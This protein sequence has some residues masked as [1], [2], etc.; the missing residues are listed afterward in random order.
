MNCNCSSAKTAQ[1]IGDTFTLDMQSCHAITRLDFTAGGD[2]RD[3]PGQ[4][5]VTVSSDCTTAANGD[6][7][8]T[9]TGFTPTLQANE[10][11]AM[12]GKVCS[13]T[14]SP[15][16]FI[17]NFPAGTNARCIRMKLT[18]ILAAGGGIWWAIDELHV[19]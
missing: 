12:D 3:V 6:I 2:P 15:C 11:L 17:V 19:K 13:Q 1:A 9:F 18:K 16:T 8:G 14:F 5:E 4:V 7:T 10:P